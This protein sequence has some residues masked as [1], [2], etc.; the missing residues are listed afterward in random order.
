MVA[1][2]LVVVVTTTTAAAHTLALVTW[3][4]TVGH[5][6]ALVTKTTTVAHMLALATKTT[7]P[8][9]IA[10]AG[11]M[12]SVALEAPKA[13]EPEALD[14]LTADTAAAETAD[15][16]PQKAGP[17]PLS[18]SCLAIVTLYSELR[19]TRGARLKRFNVAARIVR[20]MAG[21]VCAKKSTNEVRA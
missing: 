7:T 20:P 12:V 2:I 13:W 14:L 17:G 15:Q 3:T 16:R 4:T 21:K 9:H 10:A 6:L 18:L 19:L 1:A 8:A 5:T 11:I